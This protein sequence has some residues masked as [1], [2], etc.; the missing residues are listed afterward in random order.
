MTPSPQVFYGE[1]THGLHQVMVFPELPSS[2]SVP[3]RMPLMLTERHHHCGMMPYTGDDC[4]WGA[5]SKFVLFAFLIVGVVFF[6]YVKRVVCDKIP[7][8]F[9]FFFRLALCTS[10]DSTQH[11]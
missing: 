10:Q 3:V 1:V 9:S 6:K 5:S 8:S 11:V 2:S 4:D 7:L